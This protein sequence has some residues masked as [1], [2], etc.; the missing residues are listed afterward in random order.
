MISFELKGI[1][2]SGVIFDTKDR[3]TSIP[4]L[5]QLNELDFGVT[6]SGSDIVRIEDQS[7]FD[8]YIWGDSAP[9]R[10]QY[11]NIPSTSFYSMRNSDNAKWSI[12]VNPN[13]KGWN[14]IIQQKKFGIFTLF[15]RS[16]SGT[17]FILKHAGNEAS[18]FWF[19]VNSS[20]SV[21]HIFRN[22]ANSETNWGS[23]NN[24][25]P[26][27]NTIVAVDLICYGTSNNPVME[28][29]VNT[30]SVATRATTN[31]SGTETANRE[32]RILET[33]AAGAVQDLVLLAV[34]DWSSYTVAEINQFRSRFNQLREEKYGSI[35]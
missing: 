5:I 35:F 31:I 13:L 34:Y 15:S 25:V 4:G 14:S 12:L 19:A 18:K 30:V 7:G 8:N 27:N 23:A 26:V 29:F 21:R 10:A 17:G 22:S 2:M 28:M 20:G 16:S 11:Y 1:E 6:L 3:F 33:D 24:V 32:F 9:R